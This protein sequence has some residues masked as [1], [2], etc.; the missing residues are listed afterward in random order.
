MGQGFGSSCGTRYPLSIVWYYR[1][2]YAILR[3]GLLLE[4]SSTSTSY[5]ILIDTLGR[6]LGLFAAHQP[7]KTY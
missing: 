1:L 3:I 6:A 5:E 2:Y 7:K 4:L